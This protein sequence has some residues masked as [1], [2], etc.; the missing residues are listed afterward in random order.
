MWCPQ[1]WPRATPELP[2]VQRVSLIFNFL[3]R[4]FPLSGA[5]QITI[6]MGLMPGAARGYCPNSSLLF[7]PI[8]DL[9]EW[10][11][12][13]FR[14]VETVTAAAENRNDRVYR[15]LATMLVCHFY[16]R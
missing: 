3:L 2:T 11:R 10:R 9:Q 16:G 4:S 5:V 6:P 14:R 7:D 13:V 8:N 15:T 12:N 1:A